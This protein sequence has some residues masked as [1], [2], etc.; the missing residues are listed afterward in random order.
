[1]ETIIKATEFEPGERLKTRALEKIGRLEHYL[2]DLER[3]EVELSLEPTRGVEKRHIVQINMIMN[4][5]VVLRA[6][7]RA[8]DP[9]VAIDAAADTIKREL[10]RYKEQRLDWRHHKRGRHEEEVVAD[11]ALEEFEEATA[12]EEEVE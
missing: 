11:R 1:M 3:A 12:I 9:Y 5:K 8:A 4:G 7:E 2:P 6:E 10:L